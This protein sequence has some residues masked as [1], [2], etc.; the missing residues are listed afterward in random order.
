[1]YHI[2]DIIDQNTFSS[3]ME[4]NYFKRK[5]GE[6]KR[7]SIVMIKIFNISVSPMRSLIHCQEGLLSKLLLLDDNS[8]FICF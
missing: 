8:N 3:K 2:V 4:Q 5:K 6:E 1:M 7:K